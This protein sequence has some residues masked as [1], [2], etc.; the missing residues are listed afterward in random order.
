MCHA[1]DWNDYINGLRKRYNELDGFKSKYDLAEQD[2]LHYI[3]FEK[4]DAATGARLLKKLKEIR[5]QRR[6][7]KS[8]YEELQSILHKIKNAGLNNYK[9]PQKTYS[10]R[11]VTLESVLG[12]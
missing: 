9:R 4:Y 5:I 3:E 1:D 6:E 2:I 11:T 10:Y 8:E 7:I 12:E